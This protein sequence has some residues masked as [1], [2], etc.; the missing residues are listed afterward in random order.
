MS[1]KDITILGAG[2]H[3]KVVLS[4]L[5]AAGH[6]VARV[7]DDDPAKAGQ[8]ILGV[9]VLGPIALLPDEPATLAV[10]AIGNNRS[11]QAVAGRFRRVTWV[12]VVH[13]TAWVDPSAKLGPGSMIMAGAVIQA[14]SVVGAHAIVNTGASVDHDCSVGDFA[15]VAPG[16]HLAGDVRMGQGAFMGISGTA[17][18]GVAI[19]DWASAGAGAAV[20]RNVPAGAVVVGVPARTVRK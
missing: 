14:E 18:P 12:T 4:T 17:I 5:R 16:A 11:R 6:E 3:A 20:I 10:A 13:P 15:H 8:K 2:G 9:P 19:G 7:L 1:L